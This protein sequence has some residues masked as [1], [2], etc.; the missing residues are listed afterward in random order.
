MELVSAQEVSALGRK[1]RRTE[2]IQKKISYQKSYD[3]CIDH[4]NIE[5]VEAG[6]SR[7][8]EYQ[9]SFWKLLG[10]SY[11]DHYPKLHDAVVV[12]LKSSGFSVSYPLWS[13]HLHDGVLIISWPQD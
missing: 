1:R 7:V 6:K 3:K 10:N 2:R 9:F 12:A 13:D 8:T 5:L 11:I 4:L